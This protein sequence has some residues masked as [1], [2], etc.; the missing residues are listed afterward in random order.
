MLELSKKNLLIIK[1][2]QEFSKLLLNR[3]TK[4]ANFDHLPGAESFEK[5]NLEIMVI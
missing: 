2:L 4:S 1:S 5:I 3:T